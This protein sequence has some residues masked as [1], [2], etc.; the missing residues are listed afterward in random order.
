MSMALGLAALVAIPIIPGVASTEAAPSP[1]ASQ[2]V[3]CHTDAAK[4]KMLTPP[5][6]PAAETGEG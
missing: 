3:T 5:D 4:L 1:A 2:C 6:P